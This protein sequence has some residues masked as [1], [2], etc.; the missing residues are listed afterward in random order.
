VYRYDARCT[1]LSTV[2]DHVIPL[3]AGGRDTLDNMVGCCRHCH[4]V[5]SQRESNA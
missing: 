2:A 3:S 4:A 5:K 1:H